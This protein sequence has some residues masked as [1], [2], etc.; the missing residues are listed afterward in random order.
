[1]GRG[2]PAVRVARR[3]RPRPQ[4]RIACTCRWGYAATENRRDLTPVDERRKMRAIKALAIV[5]VCVLLATLS[6]GDPSFA[7]RAHEPAPGIAVVIDGAGREPI[8]VDH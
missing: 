5:T 1:M 6:T 4:R 8:L 7:S 3:P 2:R